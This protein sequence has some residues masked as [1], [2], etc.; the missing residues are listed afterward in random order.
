MRQPLG[1]AALLLL[2]ARRGVCGERVVRVRRRR[3]AS[4]CLSLRRWRCCA[5]VCV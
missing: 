4:S 5:K 1:S 2:R 3:V